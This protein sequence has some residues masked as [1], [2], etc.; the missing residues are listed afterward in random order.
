MQAQSYSKFAS[1]LTNEVLRIRRHHL[2]SPFEAFMPAHAKED[3]LV[4]LAVI[5]ELNFSAAQ[6]CLGN[7][8]ENPPN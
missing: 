5:A 4:Q 6:P 7:C 8:L 2:R 3:I 1:S